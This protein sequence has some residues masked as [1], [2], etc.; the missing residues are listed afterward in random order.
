M[1]QEPNFDIWDYFILT[2]QELGF[3]WCIETNAF[4]CHHNDDYHFCDAE[5]FYDLHVGLHIKACFYEDNTVQLLGHGNTS[6]I[7]SIA[8]PDFVEQIREYLIL[9]GIEWLARPHPDPF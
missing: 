2:L 6:A 8:E 1:D 5:M 4:G 3:A 9:C 7:I